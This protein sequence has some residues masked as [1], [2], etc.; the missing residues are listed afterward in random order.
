MAVEAAVEVAVKGAA[1]IAHAT[2][3]VGELA[4]LDVSGLSQDDFLETYDAV[5][6][7]GRLA[8]ALRARFAGDLAVSYTHLTLPTNREV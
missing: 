6:R 4:R 5:A 8:D 3:L 2:S 1:Q 7:L